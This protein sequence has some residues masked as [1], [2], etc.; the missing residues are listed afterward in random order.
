VY[1]FITRT[2]PHII[3][4]LYK[5]YVEGNPNAGKPGFAPYP[6]IYETTVSRTGI[7]SWAANH[8]LAIVEEFGANYYIDDLGKIALP[9]KTLIKLVQTASLGKLSGDHTNLTFVIQKPE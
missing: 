4:V 2:T 3:H 5:K 6:T 1:G 8:G 9:V 7:R